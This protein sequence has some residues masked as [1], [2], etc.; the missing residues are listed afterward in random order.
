MPAV[1]PARPR[2]ERSRLGWATI[3][4]VLLAV[5]VAVL[6]DDAGAISMSL[7]QYFALAVLILAAG[8]IAGTWV[9]R[10]RWLVVPALLLLPAVVMSSLVTV[11]LEGG[12]GNRLYQPLT[13]SEASH[14]YRL[15]AGRMTLDLSAL[16]T[17][18]GE[19]VSIVASVAAGDLRIIVPSNARV[20]TNAN[21]GAGEM[22]LFGR[23]DNGLKVSER[24]VVGA[25]TDGGAIT[26]HADV[27]FGQLFV[28]RR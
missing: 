19:A 15:I 27:S 8:L 2:R 6:L 25:G 24:R 13:A 9:G 11:P 10:A 18:R 28:S 22:H 16:Q 21:V 1:V 20:V 14:P 26:I 5:G 17:Q 23:W 12:F 4:A 3:G 7:G